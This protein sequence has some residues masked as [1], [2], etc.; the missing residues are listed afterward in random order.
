[1]LLV[2]VMPQLILS[3]VDR[4]DSDE[5][6]VVEPVQGG[7]ARRTEYA[8]LHGRGRGMTP[9]SVTDS[10][11]ASALPQRRSTSSGNCAHSVDFGRLSADELQPSPHRA[12]ARPSQR[13]GVVDL[14]CPATPD[15]GRDV[16]GPSRRTVVRVA[17]LPGTF[18]EV[19]YLVA[20]F[21]DRLFT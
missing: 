18:G 17:H 7:I 6:T 3:A 15:T 4:P 14:A 1:M 13:L 8:S 9:R 12:T 21:V 10:R 19:D 20:F 16:R 2:S 5:A 11:S